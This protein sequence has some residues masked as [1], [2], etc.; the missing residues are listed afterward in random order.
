M[1]GADISEVNNAIITIATNMFSRIN[2]ACSARIPRMISMA[3]RAFIASPTASD[4]VRS[5]PPR[6]APQA[7]PTSLPAQATPI[8]VAVSPR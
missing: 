6:R 4:D 8:T 3:P 5:I 7:A 1:A 2:P